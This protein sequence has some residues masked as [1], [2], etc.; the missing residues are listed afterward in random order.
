MKWRLC[1][2]HIVFVLFVSISVF[3]Q[4]AKPS[5]TKEPAWIA[6]NDINYTKTSLDKDA[7]EGSLDIYFEVQVSLAQK[8]R[9]AR[10]AIKII[11]QAGV[12]NGS[13]VSVSF[14]PSYQQ[15]IF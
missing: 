12:Q 1:L 4:S 10:R 13:M 3:S 9:Y 2:L 14:D 6:K 7:A 15:L 5:V 11:S 8:T